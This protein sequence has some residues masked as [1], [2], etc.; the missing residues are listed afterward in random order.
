MLAGD[1]SD[2]MRK[3][4]ATGSDWSDWDAHLPA[5]P[6]MS[7]PVN[8]MGSSLNRTLSTQTS[9]KFEVAE[10]TAHAV[11]VTVRG[12]G[13]GR[14]LEAL[15]GAQ[16]RGPS[17]QISWCN[18]NLQGMQWQ[19]HSLCMVTSTLQSFV[20]LPHGGHQC[21]RGRGSQTDNVGGGALARGAHCG[22][23]RAHGCG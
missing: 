7:N 21:R 18:W 9:N 13:D 10:G 14:V 1:F 15:Y 3:M 20:I 23:Q 6:T 4:G 16:L 12:R 11:L 19:E 22:R 2:D 8:S 17:P 5:S